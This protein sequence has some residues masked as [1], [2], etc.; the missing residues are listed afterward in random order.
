MDIGEALVREEIRYT[1][2]RYISAVDRSAYH[3]LSDVFTPDGVMQFGGLPP[4]KGRE[5]IIAAMMAGADRRGA[6]QPGNFSRHVLGQS[7]INVLDNATARSIHYIMMVS[8]IGLDHSGVYIDD[9]VKMG[10]RWLIAHR[11]GNL[12]WAHRDSRYA[13]STNPSN[14]P[15]GPTPRPKLDLGFTA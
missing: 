15:P 6:G 4:L 3:E 9:F 1:I 7:I 11:T 2:G 13:A 14:P 12:E 5:A 8:E 10:D